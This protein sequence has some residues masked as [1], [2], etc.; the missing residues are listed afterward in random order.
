MLKSKQAV[1]KD[2]VFTWAFNSSKPR[3]SGSIIHYEVRMNEDG[4]ISCDCPGWIFAKKGAARGCKHTRQIELEAK[5]NF[6]KWKNGEM[7]PV[8]ETVS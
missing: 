7:L 2:P 5:V 4:S 1:S 3:A 8:M 6:K